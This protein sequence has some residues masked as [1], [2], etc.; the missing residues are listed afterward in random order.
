MIQLNSHCLKIIFL[1]SQHIKP[2]RTVLRLGPTQLTIVVEEPQTTPF[3]FSIGSSAAGYEAFGIDCDIS[4]NSDDNCG[5]PGD[6]F[7]QQAIY[8]AS[9]SIVGSQKYVTIGYSSD[10]ST[11]TGLGLEFT[12]KVINL[13]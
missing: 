4:L 8:V 9:S 3:E 2:Q 10:D 1:I 5:T 11:T 12:M 7:N 6:L 13:L